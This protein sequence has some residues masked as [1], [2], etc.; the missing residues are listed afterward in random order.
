[1]K[2]RLSLLTGSLIGSL[3]CAVIS[4]IVSFF[5]FRD[6]A[7]AS[8][9]GW[10]SWLLP[11]PADL[12]WISAAMAGIQSRR[13]GRTVPKSTWFS[14]LLGLSVSVAANML[15]SLLPVMEP[16]Q[17]L[18]LAMAVS[19][20]APVAMFLAFEQTLQIWEPKPLPGD[21]PESERLV[22]V[23][24]AP[25]SAAEAK[26]NAVYE[27]IAANPGASGREVGLEFGF[28]DSY[29]RKFKREYLASTNGDA[30]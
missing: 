7:L 13:T 22:T 6:V 24:E 23:T 26:R 11:L 16:N 19:A 12:L 28:A 21:L 14:L 8:G 9:Q 30:R 10:L 15:T 29:G 27:W 18:I 1:M 5:H 3:G 17:K 20:W 25:V 2:F 4:F